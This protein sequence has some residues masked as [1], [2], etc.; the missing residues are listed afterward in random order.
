MRYLH[1]SGVP[2]ALRMIET[3]LVKVS[4]AGV[5]RLAGRGAFGGGSPRRG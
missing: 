5:A 4:T 1:D 2:G 3:S